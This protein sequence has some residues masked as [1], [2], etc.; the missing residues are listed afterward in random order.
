MWSPWIDNI[1]RGRG[2]SLVVS[3]KIVGGINTDEA[4]ERIRKVDLEMGEMEG[5]VGRRINGGS[6]GGGI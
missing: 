2:A 1:R 5:D 6:N 4:Q 3:S